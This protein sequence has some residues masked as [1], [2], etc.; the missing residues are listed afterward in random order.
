MVVVW[1]AR[2]RTTDGPGG[3]SDEVE[4]RLGRDWLKGI[5]IAILGFAGLIVVI[6]LVLRS[7]ATGL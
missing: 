7:T 5:L 4:R 1:L 2:N 3:T 6:W